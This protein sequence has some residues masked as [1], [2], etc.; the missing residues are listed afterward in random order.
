MEQTAIVETDIV[1]ADADAL[2]E[3]SDDLLN[4]REDNPEEV[5]PPVPSIVTAVVAAPAQLSSLMVGDKNSP[6]FKK[7]P[8]T[9]VELAI[10]NNTQANDSKDLCLVLDSSVEESPIFRKKNS[11]VCTTAQNSS[12]LIKSLIDGDE[13]DAD[14]SAAAISS[15]SSAKENCESISNVSGIVVERKDLSTSVNDKNEAVGSCTKNNTSISVRR[16]SKTPEDL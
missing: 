12:D 7:R 2:S 9:P 5:E 15:P 3:A 8:L 16:R 1:S 6:V 4:D 10:R 14:V 13:N 11:S